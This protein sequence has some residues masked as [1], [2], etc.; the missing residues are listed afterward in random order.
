MKIRHKEAIKLILIFCLILG[1]NAFLSTLWVSVPNPKSFEYGPILSWTEDPKSTITITWQWNE[2]KNAYVLVWN[3]TDKM[4]YNL[5][6]KA[7]EPASITIRGLSPYTEYYYLIGYYDEGKAVNKTKIF[8]FR[9]APADPRDF[10]VLVI[11]DTQVFFTGLGMRAFRKLIEDALK[12]DYDFII[13]VGDLVEYSRDLRMWSLFLTEIT[14][15]ACEHPFMAVLG[16]H[17]YM[18]Y[19]GDRGKNFFKFLALPGN[20]IWYY[21]NYSMATFIALGVYDYENFTFPNDEKDMLEKAL[22]F[23]DKWRI[24]YFHIPIRPIYNGHWNKSIEDKLLPIFESKD[25]DLVIMAH[26]HG[27]ARYKHDKTVYVQLSSASWFIPQL[28]YYSDDLESYS[29]EYGYCVLQVG[30]NSIKMQFKNLNGEILDEFVI[31]R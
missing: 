15:I 22:D 1:T 7:M 14:K 29:F 20:E 19:S 5:S 18:E 25:P 12:E 13:H 2:D 30:A 24:V 28:L 31:E 21:F 4:L 27:Y 17:D 11:S 6:V 3:N 8:K 10:K 16:N 26:Q 23:K 9:T